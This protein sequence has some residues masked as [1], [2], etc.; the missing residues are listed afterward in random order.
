VTQVRAPLFEDAEVEDEELGRATSVFVLNLRH[1]GC[2]GKV[3]EGLNYNRQS[4]FDCRNPPD[5][6]MKNLLAA[7][8]FQARTA[9]PAGESAGLSPESL[10][11]NT[12]IVSKKG[13]AFPKLPNLRSGLRKYL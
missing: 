2:W 3:F 6:A 8:S 11:I 12:P 9:E 7:L 5:L 13:G 1:R 4:S 10:G